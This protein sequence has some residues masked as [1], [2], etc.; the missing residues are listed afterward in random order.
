MGITYIKGTILTD[1]ECQSNWDTVYD[2]RAHICTKRRDTSFCKVD[3]RGLLVCFRGSKL[4][5]AGLASWGEEGC[6][7]SFPDVYTRVSTYRSWLRK[8][9]GI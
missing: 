9:M 1:N 3:D 2:S 5:L 4:V 8:T 6:D 7:R